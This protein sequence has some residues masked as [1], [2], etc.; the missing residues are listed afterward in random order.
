[1]TTTT[2]NP[3]QAE[4]TIVRLS[5]HPFLDGLNRIQ[6][7]LLA[8]CA[9]TARFKP[10]EIIFR[11][12]EKADRFY[13]IE[14]GQVALESGLDYGEPVVIDTI[15]AGDLLGWSWMMPPYV[16]HFTA[17]AVE[18]TEAIYFAGDI[19]H[20]YCHRDH[21]LGFE[22]HKRISTVMMKRLQAA[23]KK[24]LAVHS[25]QRLQPSIGR[26]PFMEQEFDTISSDE[27]DFTGG[28]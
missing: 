17:R 11:E 16:W 4:A 3:W 8:D 23:R 18:S 15:G 28:S 13:L 7:S 2:E 25:G 14:R 10:G 21:S 22:L 6:I 5:Q 26:S 27:S 12:G 24:M 19:L 20:D 1:M 9:L